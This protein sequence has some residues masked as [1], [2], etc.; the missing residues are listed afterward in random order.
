ML[1]LQIQIA[2]IN[3]LLCIVLVWKLKVDYENLSY[4]SLRNESAFLCLHM[5]MTC[6]MRKTRAK[7]QEIQPWGERWENFLSKF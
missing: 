2:Q 7:S 6:V 4:R 5:Q 3:S 1:P